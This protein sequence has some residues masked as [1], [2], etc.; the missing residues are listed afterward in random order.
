VAAGT[1]RAGARG[2]RDRR[3]LAVMVTSH[4][5]Q[6]FYVGGLAVSYPLVVAAFHVSYGMLGVVLTAAGLAGGLLQGA[7]GLIQR[8]SARTVL[9]V[10]NLTLA[11][12]TALG[13]VAPGFAVFGAA[14]FAGSAVSWPQHP[15]GS[16]YLSERFP[17]RRGAALSWHSV[18]GSLG[19]VAVPLF[20]S[21]IIA[22]AGWRWG[23][24]VLAALIAA[25]G[26]LVWAALPDGRRADPGTPEAASPP[27][28]AGAPA[29]GAPGA[30]TGAGAGAGRGGAQVVADHAGAG[31]RR[32]GAGTPPALWRVLLRRRVALVL[33][34]ATVAAGG[35]GLGT[36][37]TYLPAYL[38]S[39]LHLGQIEVGVVFTTVMAASVAGP[40]AAGH[41]ADRLGRT[42]LLVA[43][44]LAGA[45]A[46][47]GLAFAGPALAGLLVTAVA[48]GVLA[49]AESPL[50]QAVFADAVGGQDSRAAFGAFFAIAYG[51]G[52]IWLAVLGW[53]IDAF[54]F[55]ASFMVMAASFVAAAGLVLAARRAPQAAA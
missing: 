9:T 32:A 1:V 11:A 51:V 54:G 13:A 55:T 16:A 36:I 28:A 34:A 21:A 38:R 49:Y 52:A 22:S 53:V 2:H 20:T 35:R 33:A 23:L 26:L 8:L 30:G 25:G 48:V 37:T 50:L 46:L 41:L 29:A 45:V 31:P 4:A 17:H 43:A 12:A 14:R 3:A 5:V 27:G 42:R 7:A 6:H 47:A 24:A 44:Y 19:T 10:Q 40:V 39:G 18:G 15:V